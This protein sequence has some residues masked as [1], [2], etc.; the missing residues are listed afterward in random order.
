MS[1]SRTQDA[2]LRFGKYE[3]LTLPE[4]VLRDPDTFFW[5]YE[6]RKF[7]GRELAFE[8][9]WIAR[10]A[11]HIKLPQIDQKLFE[12][13]YIFSTYGKLE[14][15]SVVSPKRHRPPDPSSIFRKH[16]D[17]SV[18]YE[19]GNQDRNGGQFI[20]DVLKYY[21]FYDENTV[22]TKEICEEFFENHDNF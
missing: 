11:R 6:N 5:R 19:E 9:S 18:P 10:D 17:L 14:H 13:E 16:F 4:L 15:V 22:L 2:P 3:G 12:V 21:V 7:G 8:A 20:I 1:P